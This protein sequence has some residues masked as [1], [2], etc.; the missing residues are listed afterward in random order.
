MNKWKESISKFKKEDITNESSNVPK[1]QDVINTAISNFEIERYHHILSELKMLDEIVN[2]YNFL[3]E[4][5]EIY[6]E[7]QYKQIIQKIE[8]LEEEK[9]MIC[10]S[11][12]KAQ[13]EK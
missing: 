10:A 8:Q 7:T 11:Y 1:L 12:N 4:R 2:G 6:N 5:G 13:E 9:K 3:R